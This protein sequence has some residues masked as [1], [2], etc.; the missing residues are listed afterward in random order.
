MQRLNSI[1]PRL[2]VCEDAKDRGG[3]IG[4][5]LGKWRLKGRWALPDRLAEKKGSPQREKERS[6]GALRVLGGA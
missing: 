6:N 3:S 2:S 5:W 4:S 1:W